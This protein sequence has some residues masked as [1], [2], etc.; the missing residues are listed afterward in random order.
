MTTHKQNY[1]HKVRKTKK[2]KGKIKEEIQKKGLGCLQ[3]NN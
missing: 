2:R 1:S 3:T